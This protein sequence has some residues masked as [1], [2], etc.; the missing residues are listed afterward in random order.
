MTPYYIDLDIP[1][2][3]EGVFYLVVPVVAGVEGSLGAT[4]DGTERTITVPCL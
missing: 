3:G 2:K 1:P 4:S